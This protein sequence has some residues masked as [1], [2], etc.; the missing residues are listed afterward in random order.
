MENQHFKAIIVVKVKN[1]LYLCIV[2]RLIDCFR[3]VVIFIV[4]GF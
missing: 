3:L 1:Q 4:L 2:K